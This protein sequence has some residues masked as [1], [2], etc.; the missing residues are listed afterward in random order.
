[1]QNVGLSEEESGHYPVSFQGTDSA[2]P[3]LCEA[4]HRDGRVLD[5]RDCVLGRDSV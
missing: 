2:D 1:M 5:F 3:H 4:V